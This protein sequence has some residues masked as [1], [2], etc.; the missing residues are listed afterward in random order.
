L[1]VIMMDKREIINPPILYYASALKST[2]VAF[3]IYTFR[4]LQ[5]K[6]ASSNANCRTKLG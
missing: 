6:K 3:Y 2:E 5:K 4:P 1:R